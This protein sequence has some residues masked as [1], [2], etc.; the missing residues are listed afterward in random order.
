MANDLALRLIGGADYSDVNYAFAQPSLDLQFAAQ[1]SL[2]DQKSGNNLITFTRASSATY[3]NSTG[4]IQSAVTNLLLRSEEFDIGVTWPLS[5]STLPVITVNA[6]IS[7]N[8]SVT[9]D[10]WTRSITGSS[11]IS[12]AIAKPATVTQYTFS[13]FVKKS[14][15]DFCALRVQGTY[16]ARADV[17]FDIASGSISSAANVSNGFT[18]ASASIIPYPNNWYR[19]IFTATSDTSTNYQCIISF[20]SNN[21][22][23]DGTDSASNS[24]G[25]LWGAQLEQSSTVGEYISTTTTINSAPRFDHNPTTRESLGLLIESQRTNLLTFSAE[26]NNASWSNDNF[27]VTADAIVSPDGTLTGDKLAANAGSSLKVA[28]KLSAISITAGTV[29][30]ASVYVKNSGV[31]YVSFTFDDNTTTN[32]VTTTFDLTN[33]T[34]SRA[35]AAYG[36]GASAASS[37]NAVGNGW[38][39]ITITGTA[40]TTSVLGRWAISIQPSGTTQFSNYTGNGVDG[41]FVWGT[42][43]EAGSFSSSYIPTSTNAATRN[44]DVVSIA[45]TNFSSFYNQTEGT[46]FASIGPITNGQTIINDNFGIASISSNTFN[47]GI[48]LFAGAGSVPVFSVRDTSV[49]QAYLSGIN[50]IQLATETKIAAYYAVNSF[51]RSLRGLSPEIDTS[52]TVPIGLTQLDIGRVATVVGHLNGTIRRITYFSQKLSDANLQRMTQ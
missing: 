23:V 41:I 20:N 21:S 17:V 45:G 13:V 43:L 18:G 9:A 25:F 29:Y 37:I 44:A 42:Q 35:A 39:R 27:T 8:G 22:V 16:P 26:L 31:Q 3:V 30:T 32:G 1:K 4:T 34:I 40:G 47:N 28:R 19:L 33:G 49:D 10:L 12:Q 7:P 6:S 48:H 46:L 36:T 14:V 50:L 15:G 11:F 5:G 24:A 38:Y 2:I 51:A 52:G